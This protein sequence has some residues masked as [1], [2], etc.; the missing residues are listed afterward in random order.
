MLVYTNDARRAAELGAL[1]GQ[2]AHRPCHARACSDSPYVFSACMQWYEYGAIHAC[3]QAR[4][5]ALLTN[6]QFGTAHGPTLHA[7]LGSTQHH[8]RAVSCAMMNADHLP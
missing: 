6:Q 4:R 5:A 3:L 2:L 8:Q 7:E 1:R